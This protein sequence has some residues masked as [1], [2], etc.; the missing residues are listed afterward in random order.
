VDRPLLD[1][2][3]TCHRSVIGGVRCSTSSCEQSSCEQKDMFDSIRRLLERATRSGA[4]ESRGTKA[5][6]I[7]VRHHVYGERLDLTNK[8]LILLSGAT[9]DSARELIP[10]LRGSTQMETSMIPHDKIIAYN[11]EEADEIHA[12]SNV[13]QAGSKLSQILV[14]N[15]KIIELTIKG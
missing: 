4:K 14:R 8:P 6:T 2:K 7:P 5:D 9:I 13:T 1:G 3:F 11:G 12:F 15:G 10:F